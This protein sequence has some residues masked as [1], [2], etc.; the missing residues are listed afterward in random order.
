MNQPRALPPEQAAEQ[1][2]IGIA[3]KQHGLEEHHRHRPDRGR[4]AELRQHHFRKHRLDQEQQQRRQ[5]QRRHAEDR[6]QAR[7]ID[8]T[9]RLGRRSIWRILDD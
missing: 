2:G 4:T 7:I 6:Q 8:R 5:E 1:M 3:G 9:R